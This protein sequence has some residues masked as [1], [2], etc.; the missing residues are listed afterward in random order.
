MNRVLFFFCCILLVSCGNAGSQQKDYSSAMKLDFETFD[1]LFERYRESA[2]KDRR[3]KHSDVD[4]LIRLREEREVLHAQQ[5]GQ[6]FQGRSITELTYGTGDIKVM[7]WSQMHGDEPTATMALFDLFNFLEG[8]NDDGVQEVRD[9]LRERLQ[10]HF[11][12][13]LNPDGAEIYNRRNAQS[14]D[15]NRD[16]RAGR[17]VEGKLLTQRAHDVKPDFGFNLHDQSI[18]YHVP[19]TKNPVT[20]SFL[21]PAYNEEKDVNTTRGNAMK[22]IGGMNRLLQHYIPDAVAKYD[23]TYSP[24]GFGDNFQSWGASTVLIESG[25]LKDDAEKQQIRKFNFVI[26]LNALMEIAQGS[27]EQYDIKEYDDIP[28]NGSSLLHNVFIRNLEIGTDSI[29]LKVDVAVRLSE[30]TAGREYFVR[31]RINDM[32]DLQ[33][34]FGYDE[35][36]AEGLHFVQGGVAPQSIRSLGELSRERAFDLLK[37]GY[38]AVRLQSDLGNQ[39][40]IHDLPINIFTQNQFYTTGSVTLGGTANFYLANSEGALK[41]A[42]VNG[43]LIDLEKE[44]NQVYRNRVE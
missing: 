40:V 20:M 4:S 30:T 28:F 42:I 36:D 11:I 35:I 9:L 18:Y 33:E 15:L 38:L 10:I 34:S 16:A 7:L 31:G 23:D 24:R 13:M 3:F 39:T 6:S 44:N 25:G 21:A 1:T 43:Y 32:G 41:Y 29:P 37:Q 2:L 27:Y 14:I 17:T 22:L 19:S 26:I 8:N 12:P 5:I